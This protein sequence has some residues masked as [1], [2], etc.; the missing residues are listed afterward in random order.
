MA[1]KVI[2][3][4]LLTLVQ[5]LG[6]HGYQHLGVTTGGPMDEMAFRWANALLDNDE[7]DSQ[8][9]ITFG[10]LTLEAQADTS[11]ALC[12]AD[13]GATLN[14]DS[15]IPWQTYAIKAGDVLAFQQP[16]NGLRAYL[17][18]K[19]GFQIKPILG[20]VSTVVREK[21]GGL[22]GKGDKLQKGDMLAYIACSQHRQRMV[23]RL[24][25]PNYNSEEIPMVLSYQAPT[26]SHLDQARFFGNHYAVSTESDRMGYR[27]QG[28]PIGNNKKGIISEGIAYGAI[29]IPNDGQ[30]I[31]LLRDRQTIGG[32]PKMGCV[33]PYGGGLLSQK[34]PGDKV[35]FANW[36]I[37]Q[38]ERDRH[39]QIAR[40]AQWR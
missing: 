24:A 13:L 28:Q 5:D 18:V 34:K 37:D 16:K 23:P 21:I 29:Q 12:G 4:G 19:W 3:P 14:G 20:S 26:F 30:P 38:V 33:T 25:I 31:V 11:I 8:L 1:F 39:L 17:A 15:V 9:E 10:M 7:N 36:T 2:K 40:V 6:R 32:Y 27:L 35:H 22:S